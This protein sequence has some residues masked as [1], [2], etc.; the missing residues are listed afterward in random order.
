MKLPDLISVPC[1]LCNAHAGYA[2][3]GDPTP[4]LVCHFC[5]TDNVAV[6]HF[7]GRASYDYHVNAMPQHARDLYYARQEASLQ[8]AANLRV[9]ELNLANRVSSKPAK[10]KFTLC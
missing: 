1:T 9:I 2:I 3:A 10:V 4:K 7:L 6:Q 5:V 8:V